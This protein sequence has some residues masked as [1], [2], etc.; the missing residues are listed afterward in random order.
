MDKPLAQESGGVLIKLSGRSLCS[1][2]V[3]EVYMLHDNMHL[4]LS[5]DGGNEKKNME[6]LD[7]MAELMVLSNYGPAKNIILFGVG[8]EGPLDEDVMRGALKKAL[9]GFPRFLSGVR[10]HR[11]VGGNRLVWKDQTDQEIPLQCS[12]FRIPDESISFEDCL[13]AHLAPSLNK[14]WDLLRT[15]PTEFHL[16]RHGKGRHS[17][18]ALVHHAAARRV[19]DITV[20][21][22]RSGGLP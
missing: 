2:P 16:L 4:G 21:Q 14:D 10:E 3:S 9:D 11:Y 12:E 5:K 1:G 19:D 18:I 8:L 17:F 13:L 20:H 22:K 15:V 6:V 7:G